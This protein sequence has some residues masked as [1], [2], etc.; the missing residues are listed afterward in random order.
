MKRMLLT[1]V[2]ILALASAASAAP[3]QVT[4][5]QGSLLTP[6]GTA[7]PDGSYTITFRLYTVPVA[8]AAIWAETQNLQVEGSIFNAILGNVSPLTLS[9]DS[10]YWLGVTIQG[11]PEM[12]FQCRE[13]QGGQEHQR[14]AR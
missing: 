9:F 6:S 1:M 3:P 7:V 11:D 12:S 10:Q 8:G 4:N 5:V 14:P 2:A 13:R